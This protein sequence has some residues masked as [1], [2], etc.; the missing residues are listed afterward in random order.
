MQEYPRATAPHGFMSG[1]ISLIRGNYEKSIAEAKAALDLEPD[2]PIAYSN[3]ALSYLA[4]DRVDEAEKTLR[5]AS[6]RKL[7]IPDFLI[8]RYMIAF[9]KGDKAAM[10]QEAAQAHGDPVAEEWMANSEGFVL[11]YAGRLQEARIEV[12]TGGEFRPAS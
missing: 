3:L 8:Q 1:N 11:A 5:Q 4:L 12:P 9:L 2:L 7:E 6:E 10:E